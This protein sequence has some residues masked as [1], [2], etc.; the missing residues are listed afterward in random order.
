M[1]ATVLCCSILLGSSSFSTWKTMRE[2]VLTNNS[3]ANVDCIKHRES[4]RASINRELGLR[5]TFKFEQIENW[6]LSNVFL[7]EKLWTFEVNYTHRLK[8][9]FFLGGKSKC[10]NVNSSSDISLW[11][12]CDEGLNKLEV[13]IL[14]KYKMAADLWTKSINF[15][16]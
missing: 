8:V 10:L 4:C 13:D 11:S 16:Y 1:Q 6:N 5:V 3:T 2:A 15:N 14:M 12:S 7:R 9:E